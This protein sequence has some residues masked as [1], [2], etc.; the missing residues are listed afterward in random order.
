MSKRSLV[1]LYMRQQ[2]ELAMPDI[3]FGPASTAKRVLQ[4]LFPAP[5]PVSTEAARAPGRT[6]QPPSVAAKNPLSRLHQLAPIP[7][8]KA[9]SPATKPSVKTEPSALMPPQTGPLSFEG[10]RAVLKELFTAR[11]GGCALAETRRSFVFGAGNVDAPLMVIGE[12]PGAEEDEQGLPFVGAAGR[13]LTEMLSAVAIDRKKDIFITNILKCRPPGN[14][15]P[16]SAEILACMPLLEKQIAIVAPRMLLLL[17]RIAA[18]ALLGVPDSIVKLRATAHK[19]KRI[20][21]VVTYHPAAILRNPEYRRPAEEDL[22]MVVQRL[23]E[24]G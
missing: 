18:H 10:K 7:E 20:P 9:Q 11:C 5:A 3:V 16:E 6:V 4:A 12:A 13:L 1:A 21:A 8:R 2:R 24:N 23:K 17:G 14:R 19:Y 15:T 22:Q